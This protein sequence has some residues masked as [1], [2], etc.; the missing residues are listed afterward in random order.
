FSV[1]L[2]HH[3]PT[4]LSTLSLHDALPILYI[5]AKENPV[6][7]GEFEVGSLIVVGA[8]LSSWGVQTPTPAAKIKAEESSEQPIVTGLSDKIPLL[9]VN[10]IASKKFPVEIPPAAEIAS[11]INRV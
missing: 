11:K 3:S 5:P 7:V 9:A 2:Y 1:F 4:H 8:G 10:V 6:I